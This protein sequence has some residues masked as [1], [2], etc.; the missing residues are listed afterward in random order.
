V[1][2]EYTGTPMARNTGLSRRK[3]LTKF[4]RIPIST[5]DLV[6]KS[7]VAVMVSARSRAFHCDLQVLWIWAYQNR[8][9]IDCSRRRKPTDNVFV[10]SFDGTLRAVCLDTHWFETLAEAEESIESWRQ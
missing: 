1:G 3:R 2:N 9:K 4:Q 6:S 10:E 5:T 7:P 8:V